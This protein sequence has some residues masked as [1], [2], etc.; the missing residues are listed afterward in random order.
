MSKYT[1]K[2][3]FGVGVGIRPLTGAWPLWPLLCMVCT[4]DERV[5]RHLVAVLGRLELYVDVHERARR[6]KVVPDGR[7]VTT[8]RRTMLVT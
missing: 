7:H 1:L 4:F 3:Y 2:N 6:A 5:H 8:K